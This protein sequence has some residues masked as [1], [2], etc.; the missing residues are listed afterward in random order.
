MGFELF[1]ALRYLRSKRR[2]RFVSL[3]T[4]I[5][6]AGVSVGV[7]ALIVVMSVMTGFDNALRET[8]IGNR[9]HVTVFERARL[10]MPDPDQVMRDI[11]TLDERIAASGPIIQV[12]AL[13]KKN[14]VA[15]GALV[16][17]VDPDRERE[18]TY[19]EE[20][21]GTSGG[22]QY[23]CGE[24]PKE[25]EIILGYRL[26]QRLGATLGSEIAVITAK[27]TVRPI[28]GKSLGSQIWLRVS[29]IS[30][31]RMSEFDQLYAFV[32]IPTARMISGREGV[33]AVH[34]KLTDPFAANEVVAKI[35]ANTPY[36]AQTWYENQ[37]AYF[38]ALKQE[39]LAMFIILASII[40]VAAFNITSTL[41]MIVMEKRRDIG[42][43]RTLGASTG[44]I[45]L[46]FVLEG[47]LIGLSGTVI[48]VSLGT[49][50][51]YYINPVASFLA[52][53]FGIDLF[54][55]TIYYF[56]GI[57]VAIVPWDVFWITLSAVVLT[58]VSTIYPAWSAVR[59][60]PV[61]ALRYE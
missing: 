11:E 18:V 34:A 49:C 60:N 41:I 36:T 25:K 9:A 59:V 53:L 19:L 61:D 40:L 56:D 12:E 23:G 4:I 57:P 35:E 45:L 6:I 52:S 31:A 14:G 21:L 2:N 43:L 27:S 37:E 7:I 58:F 29:G 10:T 32:D 3:I 24:L 13:L 47:L 8:I 5:S 46:I 39:K 50:L 38:E 1:I 20:N 51:A 55:S 17:G 16:L 33:D 42:I 54:N 26:A 44:S 15:T 30:Q 48:G 22:R 28:M